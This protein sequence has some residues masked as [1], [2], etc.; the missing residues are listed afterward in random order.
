MAGVQEEG[1]I[2]A[3]LAPLGLTQHQLDALLGLSDFKRPLSVAVCFGAA[4]V[5]QQLVAAG[6]NVAGSWSY[7]LKLAAARATA[8]GGAETLAAAVECVRAPR[9]SQLKDLTGRPGEAAEAA[10]QRWLGLP[11]ALAP[12]GGELLWLAG[13]LLN[14][15]VQLGMLPLLLERQAARNA[16]LQGAAA[17]QLGRGGSLAAEVVAA[18]ATAGALVLDSVLAAGGRVSLHALHLLLKQYVGDGSPAAVRLLLSR[19]VPAVPQDGEPARLG[20]C[21]LYAVLNSFRYNQDV[22]DED[23]CVIVTNTRRLGCIDMKRQQARDQHLVQLEMMEALVAA[24]YRPI[25]YCRYKKRYSYTELADFFPPGDPEVAR[26]WELDSAGRWLWRAALHEPWS[27]ATHSHFPRA[28]Q[29]AARSLLLVAHRGSAH[30][31]HVAAAGGRRRSQRL[32][33]RAAAAA[34][35]HEGAC[36][37]GMLPPGVLLRVLGLAAYPLSAWRP[38]PDGGKV[39][40]MLR[41]TLQV[42][43]R[44]RNSKDYLPSSA[45]PS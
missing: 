17:T 1:E 30:A 19:G 5:A 3:L 10:F 7:L 8:A 40:Q 20:T 38:E 2:A 4:D 12:D 36:L 25:T 27:I 16:L 29:A 44:Y 13:R 35:S 24:G 14:H 22:L 34:G 23:V 6:A 42:W 33:D 18:A 32:R 37:L 41:F 43:E 9:A 31:A 21:P 15:G 26:R 45:V 39:W 11:A 28:F